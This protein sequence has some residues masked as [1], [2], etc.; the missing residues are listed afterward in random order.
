MV[1]AR[2]EYNLAGERQGFADSAPK[3]LMYKEVEVPAANGQLD[4]DGK[5]FI[6]LLDRR[7]GWGTLRVFCEVGE[8]HHIFRSNVI[9]FSRYGGNG[10]TG[11]LTEIFNLPYVFGSGLLRVQGKVSADALYGADC[12]NFIIYGKRREGWNIPYVDPK[13]LL[14]YLDFINDFE[15]FQGEVAYGRQGPI[16][17]TPELVDR[18]L[19]LHLGKHVAAVFEADGGFLTK[20]TRVVHQLESYPEITTFGALAQKYKQIRIMTFKLNRL[21]AEPR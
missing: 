11:N 9:C 7:T 4:V 5:T 20:R 17:I 8:G 3:Y 2:E 18:G 12:S 16:S 10:Y 14:P 21:P 13:D 19:L 15:G 1:T 6:P